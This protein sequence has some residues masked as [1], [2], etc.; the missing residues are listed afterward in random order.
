MESTAS[1]Y[2]NDIETRAETFANRAMENLKSGKIKRH[3]LPNTSVPFSIERDTELIQDHK[4]LTESNMWKD[5]LA[6]LS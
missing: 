3:I 4:N 1:M 2:A 6:E 5:F